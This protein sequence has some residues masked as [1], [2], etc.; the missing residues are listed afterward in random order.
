MKSPTNN[1]PVIGHEAR[2]VALAR[3]FAKNEIPQSLL[4]SGPPQIGKWTLARRY[5]Q[6]LLCPTPILENDL[7]AP[8]GACRVCHQVAIETFPDFKVYRPLVSSAEDERDWVFAP[9]AMSSSVLPIS[10]ARKFG[11]EAM[12]KPLVG[13][14]KVMILVQADR[15]TDDAQN[16]LLKTFEEPVPGLSIFLLCDNA[17]QLLATILSRCWNIPLGF[18]AD[19]QIADWLRAGSTPD[20]TATSEEQI[21]IAVRAARGRPGVAKN[22]IARL[23]YFAQNSAGE[24]VL[25][26][27]V[28]AEAFLATL[29]HSAPLGALGLTE[30]ALRLAKDWW[31]E[32]Q[33]VAAQAGSTPATT[34]SKK[35]VK[36]SDAKIVRSSIALFLDELAGAYRARW[37][38]SVLAGFGSTPKAAQQA[39]RW[40]NGLDQIRKTRHYVLRNANS[41]LALDVLFGR[42]IEG[43]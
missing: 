23:Q 1:S 34:G 17:D 18:A 20:A 42:L 28:Q 41:N 8:C 33:S 36:K 38:R 25:P 27:P 9:K 15:M 10:V 29:L 24:T 37:T 22:E 4:F 21:A 14:R 31:D 5:A 32:D 11:G 7:P 43:C 26:R 16:A 3:A 30:E 19:A 13:P 2:W 39:A 40:S 12:R 35:E 6:L